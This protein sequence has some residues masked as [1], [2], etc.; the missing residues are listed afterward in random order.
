MIFDTVNDSNFAGD[1]IL[2]HNLVFKIIFPCRFGVG[3]V[4]IASEGGRVKENV[5]DESL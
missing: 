1:R 4:H 2:C 3:K 5:R